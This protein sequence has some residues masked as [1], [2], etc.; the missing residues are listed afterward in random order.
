MLDLTDPSPHHAGPSD[1]LGPAKARSSPLTSMGSPTGVP[2][3]CASTRPTARGSTPALRYTEVM[4]SAWAMGSGTV[5]P[6][7]CP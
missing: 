7:E 2:V 6:C 1:A 3:P 4:S 5:R